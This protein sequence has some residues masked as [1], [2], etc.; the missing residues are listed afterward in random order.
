VR[1]TSTIHIH[2]DVFRITVRYESS[3]ILAILRTSISR[4]L[5][6]IIDNDRIPKDLMRLYGFSNILDN[7]AYLQLERSQSIVLRRR[8]IINVSYAY[9]FVNSVTIFRLF[10]PINIKCHCFI[11]NLYEISIYFKKIF[12]LYIILFILVYYYY[13]YYY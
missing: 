10:M 12:P 3:H 2:M 9:N 4:D 5:L 6:P 13:F 8:F 11:N 1:D 7:I